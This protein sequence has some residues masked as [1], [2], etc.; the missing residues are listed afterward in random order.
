MVIQYMFFNIFEKSLVMILLFSS[1][2]FL[3][4]IW[5]FHVLTMHSLKWCPKK[6]AASNPSDH[7][8]V[9]L[10]HSHVKIISKVL[11]FWLKPFLF[12]LIDEAQSAYIKGH[13]I[14]NNILCTFEI[15]YH[16]KKNHSNEDHNV[17]N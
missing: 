5:T 15:L 16:S 13:T 10:I 8:P 17:C 14:L 3:S 2:N 12:D 11:A 4:I 1:N 7:R 9:N 6:K